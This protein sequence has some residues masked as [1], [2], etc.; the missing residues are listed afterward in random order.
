K[1]YQP[2]DFH[3]L[4]NQIL[5]Y[6]SYYE[7]RIDFVREVSKLLYSYTGCDYIDLWIIKDD[8]PNLFEI[9]KIKEGKFS[10]NVSRIDPK[11]NDKVTDTIQGV[12]GLSKLSRDNDFI[13]FKVDAVAGQ[14]RPEKQDIF[15][16]TINT[17]KSL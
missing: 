15:K 8:N 1:N 17:C 4:S 7:R 5:L 11:E 13:A 10:F 14:L 12:S 3:Y 9:A 2:D 16:E 6:A